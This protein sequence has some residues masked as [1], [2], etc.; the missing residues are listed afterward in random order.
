MYNEEFQRYKEEMD[1]WDKSVCLTI[2]E[3]NRNKIEE[4]INIDIE[5]INEEE[6]MVLLQ[7]CAII[8]QYLVFLQK[9]S[10]ECDAYLKW[11]DSINKKLVGDDKITCLSI[12][13]K[14]DLRKS[15]ISFMS[16][17]VEFF[18]QCIQG[19]IRQRNLENGK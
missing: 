11:S 4:I 18:C 17:R 19:I 6:T 7:Y 10:N 9:K 2:K 13:N 8:S 14:V 15:K 12:H 16:R 3:P 5:K 1:R